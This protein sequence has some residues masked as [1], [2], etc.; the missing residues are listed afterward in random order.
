MEKRSQFIWFFFACAVCLGYSRTTAAISAMHDWPVGAYYVLTA[1]LAVFALVGIYLPCA[2]LAARYGW[3]FW[4]RTEEEGKKGGL[5]LPAVGFAAFFAVRFFALF[6]GTAEGG[7]AF[8]PD[9]LLQAAA[10]LLFFG[11]IRM[12]SNAICA[13]LAVLVIA[14]M[15]CF[16]SGVCRD[17]TQSVLLFGSALLL[18]ANAFVCCR[19]GRDGQ[20][21]GLWFLSAGIADGI[22]AFLEPR[23]LCAALLTFS[24]LAAG[25]TGEGEAAGSETGRKEIRK[26][27]FFCAAFCAALLCAVSAAVLWRGEGLSAG[28]AAVWNDRLNVLRRGSGAPED[29]PGLLECWMTIPFYMLGF[30]TLFGQLPPQERK[31]SLVWLAPYILLTAADTLFGA[32]PAVR[33]LSLV[34]LGVLAGHGALQILCTQKEAAEGGAAHPAVAESEEGQMRPAWT[35][36]A[37]ETEAGRLNAGAEKTE[38]EGREAASGAGPAQAPLPGEPLRNPLPVPK[39]HVRREMGYAFEPSPELMHYDILPP[40]DDDFDL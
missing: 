33:G 20:G 16:I 12:L 36:A 1:A 21:G 40:E 15:P 39:R 32:G 31:S 24:W 25:R 30:L 17:G 13:F 10:A 11:G 2:L 27:V 34:F 26:T 22:A 5:F 37:T 29:G 7:A 3:N 8:W 38:T 9:L 14:V 23:L 19:A 6:S 18:Y 4:T 35:E 28:A